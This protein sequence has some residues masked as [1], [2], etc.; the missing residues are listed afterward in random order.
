MRVNN[1][2][3]TVLNKFAGLIT[4]QVFLMIQNDKELMQEYLNLLASGKDPHTLNCKLGKQIKSKLNLDNAGRCNK[5]KS[6][7]IRSYER[8]KIK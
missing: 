8:H 5:P 4:D 3:D 7:L 6:T 2:I 1:Y